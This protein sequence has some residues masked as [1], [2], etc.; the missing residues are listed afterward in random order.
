[1]TGPY[2]LNSKAMWQ[3]CCAISPS[4]T[5]HRMSCMQTANLVLP[6]GEW[7]RNMN[8]THYAPSCALANP[9]LL[10]NPLVMSCGS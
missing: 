5:M 2:M 1:M 6:A 9:L 10:S 8:A 3:G 4:A 7:P